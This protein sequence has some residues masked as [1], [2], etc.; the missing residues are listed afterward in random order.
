M[1]NTNERHASDLAADP[2]TIIEQA[3]DTIAEMN[4]KSTDGKWLE[5]L[6][7]QV[8]VSVK[9]W[10]ISECWH[11]SN[12]P[13]R[14]THF[15]ETT[16]QDIGI[17]AVAVR[18]GDN[19]YVAIQCKSRQL[20]HGQGADINKAEID[21]FANVSS[22]PFWAERWLITNGNAQ[23][24]RN[25]EQALSMADPDRPIKLINVHADLLFQ[26]NQDVHDT[27]PHCAPDTAYGTKQT[28]QCMQ[29]EAVSNAIRVLRE[30]EASESGGLPQ[31][32]ARGRLILPC[33]TGKTR[34][35][36]RIVEELTPNGGVSVILCP[37]IA[38]VAQI[39]REYLKHRTHDMNA[40]SVCSDQTA[41][42]DPSKES[43][44][45]TAS[46]PTLDG[47]NLS[48]AAVMGPV[49]TD[50]VEITRWIT[51]ASQRKDISVIFGT[52]Q[53]GHRIA[54]ALRSSGKTAS[55]LVADEAHRT[56]GLRKTKKE[57]VNEQV[58][59]FTLCHDNDALPA[60]YRVYQTATPKVY[61]TGNDT[62][63]PK[64]TEWIV[65]SMDDESVFG[66]E[67][68]RRSYMEA[69]ENGWLSDYRIIALG[70]NDPEA[71]R[72][73][74][75]L[76]TNTRSTGRQPL[77]TV[78]YLRGLAFALVMGG[79]TQDG[80]SEGVSIQSCIAFMNTV[81]KSKNMAQD[82][83]SDP[84]KNWVQSYLDDNLPGKK[85]ADYTLAH[86]DASSNVLARENAKGRL[87]E[88]S[89]TNPHGIINVG[90]FGEGT[91]APSLS[92]VAFLEA[93][94]SP[95]DVIQAVGRAM[96]TAPGKTMGY[97]ICPILIPPEADPEEWLQTSSKE[98]GWQELGQILLA[99]RAHDSRIEDN[100]SE[101][102]QL[103][104]PPAPETVATMVS[105]AN[106]TES[107]IRHYVHV[108]PPGQAQ[109]AAEQVVEGKVRPLDVLI[110][111][112]K[113]EEN[114]ETTE[115]VPSKPKTTTPSFL[116][117]QPTQPSMLRPIGLTPAPKLD[118]SLAQPI[119]PSMLSEIALTPA[120]KMHQSNVQVNDLH[121]VITAKQNSDLSVETRRDSI[122]RD[123]ATPNGTPG[124]VNIAKTK[125]KARSMINDGTG[126]KIPPSKPRPRK[127]AHERRN[128]NGL[129]MLLLTGLDVN[130]NAIKMNLLSKSGLTGNRTRRD[131]NILEECVTEAARHLKNDGLKEA[132]DH[133]FQLDNLDPEKRKTQADGCTITAL[134]L[135]NAA[136]LHQRIAHGHWLPDITDLT[137]VKNAA[138]VVS[139]TLRQW[140]RII[141]HDFKPV[142]EPAVKAIYAVEDTGRTAGLERAL[143]HITAEAEH[144]AENYADMGADHAGQLFNRVMGNQA[145]DG[146]YFTRPTA[147]SIAARLTLDACGDLNWSEEQVW[148]EHKTVDLACGSG[149]LLSAIL[150]DMKHRAAACGADEERLAELQQLAVE[151]TIKGLDF[152]P[153]SLQLAA[154]QL[155]AGN[156]EIRYRQMGLH[157]TP[158]GPRQD[159][160]T[161]VA[162][163]TLELLGQK[164]IIPR[165][166]ELP[167]DD[168]RISSHSVWPQED[169]EL[170][171]AI[172]AVKDARIVIMNPPF[173]NRRKMGEKFP[174]DIRHALRR[175]VDALEELLVNAD[176]EMANFG[177]KNSIGP[178]FV[179]LADHCLD[180]NV[181]ILTMIKP[182]AA[183]C[184][185]SGL[186]ERR[187]LADRYHI[188]TVL[189]CHQ[190]KQ[191]N[192][193]QNTNINESII[194]AKRHNGTK[195][196]TRFINLDKLPV[197][198][199]QVADLHECLAHCSTGSIANGWGEVFEWPT[200][201]IEE[202]DW[203][204]AIWRSPIL[205]RSAANLTNHKDL[206]TAE[207]AGLKSSFTGRRLSEFCQKTTMGDHQ[208]FPVLYSKG[209]NG[210]TTIQSTPDEY[211]GPKSPAEHRCINGVKNLREKEGYLLITQGQSNDTAR[212][213]AT[214]SDTKFVGIGWIPIRGISP[215]E[216]KAIAV[217]FNST[218]GRLQ[219]MRN[220]SRKLEFPMYNP[221]AS[222]KVRIPN[223][224]DDQ[225]R[226]ILASCW[227]QTK[228]IKVPQFRDGECEV[229]RL[230][231]EAVAE[232][233][234][235]D[236]QELARLRGLLNS[237][238]HVR[239]LG[240]NQYADEAM[241]QPAD[242]EPF[243]QLADQQE[244]ET[245]MVSSSR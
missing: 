106:R 26:Q 201:H 204:P 97:I 234:G 222:A 189:T 223:C 153:V 137:T 163:G 192:L 63:R 83:Q 180:P 87:A 58:K 22:N 9:E 183:L 3:I 52:Y 213:T 225:I 154:S 132:L 168:D 44:R 11:W 6:T 214:A 23:I 202:G 148:K 196:P 207:Q 240:Y 191:A 164:A 111:I 84:V 195:P 170:D 173:T 229:R 211:W 14:D 157:K 76:A 75:L 118:H 42:Y 128:N 166:N 188:H 51:A 131:M 125:K 186:N 91:D 32:Q 243:P 227:E 30:H 142:L 46:D 165:P 68:Y 177:D 62:S 145:S 105:V 70:V 156:R 178:L 109:R 112:S 174:P 43:T 220:A 41:G 134:L 7:V 149:T 209:A 55:V 110:P 239:G 172:S 92:A 17:D 122:V 38:L 237:E 98:D 95:I 182:T 146:A 33:G 100:L 65:R 59:N 119:Q 88:S 120:R 19:R 79:A 217:F 143:R 60:K 49:T 129:Q 155:T 215:E 219:L 5:D 113:L 141:G 16:N 226:N 199:T 108:G 152:N 114:S 197:D 35:S 104:I 81:D 121:S 135:M 123:K 221:A 54:E 73:A 127:T 208:S 10:D 218:L 102:M 89:E 205:A 53:S 242:H 15:P 230:W 160:Q 184:S 175:R 27:C 244:D 40:L 48:A 185:S 94:K 29:D 69:V 138:N 115:E 93:R 24:S 67:L 147:A 151:D 171:D 116:K 236:A 85:T 126:I 99:L 82:L 12:W 45:N 117:V 90:I 144:I 210:Q 187:L 150:T 241:V 101:L 228:N 80:S 233:M 176:T 39:R 133:H 169:A 181:G 72:A 212:L 103:Y 158:Y 200:K 206:Q 124:Q 159:N 61:D 57:N 140:N 224:K 56:A 107:Q 2:Q 20:D 28:K 139:M 37:S 34:I 136:M 66:V 235:W 198:D 231:D 74:N 238:P 64:N 77:T 190:P 13:D 216:A 130:A 25:A 78:D 4:T 1:T 71:F 179:S 162:T 18:R 47:S 31:G 232:A 167:I 203:T 21:K 50:A 245:T 36:L 161:Q 194:V 86:L 193:S 8:A 96:R